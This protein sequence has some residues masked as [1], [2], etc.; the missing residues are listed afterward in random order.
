MKYCSTRGIRD[1]S[2]EEV[3]FSGYANDGG[4]F[5]PQSI[6]I[7]SRNLLKEWT[8]LSFNAL[9]AKILSYFVSKDIVPLLPEI[10]NKAFKYFDSS[11]VVPL[12]KVGN[13][14]VCETFHGPTLTY[15][16]IGLNILAQLMEYTLIV[17]ERKTGVK[18]SANVLCETAGNTGPAAVNAVTSHC[19]H[20][21][22]FCMFPT[23]YVS[24]VQARQLTTKMP[25]H[26]NVRIY[27]TNGTSDQQALVV[28]NIFKNAEFA[29]KYNITAMNSIHWLRIAGQIIYYF[30]SYLQINKNVDKYMDF[31]I[32]SGGF[33]NTVACSFAKLM[34]LPIRHIIPCTN[35]NDIVYRTM[36]YGDFSS[37][38]KDY[39]QV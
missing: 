4:L 25:K 22:I 18:Q 1:V 15:K 33:G 9:S 31:A 37:L 3:V 14:Y 38:K 11:D 26:D 7:I 30:W 39:K 2:F 23:K 27:A 29:R 32:P 17:K 8:Q 36:M 21:N 35:R 24:D 12:K 19:K 28:K 6:P 16:D 5:V 13:I 34:G 10:C 20:V